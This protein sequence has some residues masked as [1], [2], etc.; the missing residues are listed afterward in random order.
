MLQGPSGHERVTMLLSYALVLLLAY[1]VYLIVR[2]FLVPLAWA[3]VLVIFFYP[4]QAELKDHYGRTRAAA[5]STAAVTLVLIVPALF[6]MSAFINEAGRAFLAL[7]EN[8]ASDRLS[9][10]SRPFDAV[11]QLLPDV[12]VVDV[13]ELVTKAAQEAGAWLAGRVGDFVQVTAIFL[14][15]LIVAIFA[16]FFLFRDADRVMRGVRDLLPIHER[17]RERLIHQTGE[18]VTAAV[19]SSFIVAAVQGLLGGVTFWALGI[20]APVFWGVMM[21][22]FCLLPLGAWVVWLPA[23]IWLMA[24][25]H[26]GRG[27]ILVAVGA[28][29]VSLVD[30][31]L[32]PMLLSGRTRL[33][34]L[35]MFIGLL[36]GVAA[37]GLLGIM[38][39]PVIMATA[40]G[41]LE[42][43][44][45]EV[46]KEQADTG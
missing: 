19:V 26:V 39:G 41:L 46:E 4:L 25:G 21:A 14:F 3:A 42:A 23:A 28:G 12:L 8:L 40:V 30:N 9:W 31:F 32:R 1:L 11:E 13:P 36:G 2:P 7:R 16:A 5:L 24:T 22:L 43:Y 18:V 44:T 33:N 29:I 37:F 38:L 35:L 45:E 15:N 34:G 17:L 27:I 10:I 20:T 6:V